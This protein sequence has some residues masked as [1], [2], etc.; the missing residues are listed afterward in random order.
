MKVYINRQDM[1]GTERTF[2]NSYRP[3]ED[4]IRYNRASKVY[5]VTVGDYAAVTATNHEKNEIQFSL[6]MAARSLMTQRDFPASVFTT[7]PNDH[8]LKV[9]AFSFVLPLQRSE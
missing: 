6:L 1:T 7:R 2:A 8:S 9:I 3:G 4:I 5:Q